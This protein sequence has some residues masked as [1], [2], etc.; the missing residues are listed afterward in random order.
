V[1]V[2]GDCSRGASE[3]D[4]KWWNSNIVNA[5][6]GDF[7]PTGIGFTADSHDDSKSA[8]GEAKEK[9]KTIP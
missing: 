2:S 8:T 1:P 7:S 5:W 3:T 9:L 4:S 6:N